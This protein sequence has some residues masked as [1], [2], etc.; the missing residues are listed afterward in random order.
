MWMNVQAKVVADRLED[1]PQSRSTLGAGGVVDHVL[2]DEVIED[3]GVARVASPEERLHDRLG[4]RHPPIVPD[5]CEA[6]SRA[7]RRVRR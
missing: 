1:L 3:L 5:A 4:F 7:V 6:F 2:G